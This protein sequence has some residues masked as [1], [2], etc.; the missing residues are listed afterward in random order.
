ML[1]R[2][3]HKPRRLEG[4][5]PHQHIHQCGHTH[6]R[7]PTLQL[8]VM[9]H[10]SIPVLYPLAHSFKTRSLP[11]FLVRYL[12]VPSPFPQHLQSVF[13]PWTSA[14][15]PH[16][17]LRRC[18]CPE[19]PPYPHHHVQRIK[20]S[21]SPSFHKGNPTFGAPCL[22]AKGSF[23]AKSPFFFC[24]HCSSNLC[25]KQTRAADTECGLEARPR[26]SPRQ[27]TTAVECS[28]HNRAGSNPFNYSTSVNSPWDETAE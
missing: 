9:C 8:K 15:P 18:R 20:S 2:I 21:V 27:T 22:R 13:A 25:N 1:G 24:H 7:R 26:P 11:R 12:R 16:L 23:V 4:N 6:P 19:T 5:N 10:W 17:L 3:S 28:G 14:P